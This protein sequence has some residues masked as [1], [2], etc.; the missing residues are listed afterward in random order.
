MKL[1]VS[2]GFLAALNILL[3]F[4]NQWYVLATVGPGKETDAL[5]AGMAFPQVV[6]AVLSG[7][8]AQVLVPLLAGDIDE[9]IRTEGWFCFHVSAVVFGA[10][11]VVSILFAGLWVPLLFPGFSSD[12]LSLTIELTRIQL[13]G[14]VFSGLSAVLWSVGQAR[15][16]FLW[17]AMTPPIG[18]IL[19]F[20]VLA[21]TVPWYGIRAAAWTSVMRVTLQTGVLLPLLGHYTS[22]AFSKKRLEQIMERL[23]PLVL[24][25]LYSKTG[26]L[27]DRFLSSMAPAGGL[28]LLYLAQQIYA[29]IA[30]VIHKSFT[31]S[32]IP[33]LT[34]HARNSN[35]AGFQFVYLKRFWWI[36]GLTLSGYVILA[37]FGRKTLHF[38]IGFGGVT[39]ENVQLLWWLLVVLGGVLVAGGMG[40]ISAA[41]FYAEGDTRIPAR[42]GIIGFTLG[43]LVKVFAFFHIGL[44]GIALGASVHQIFNTSVLHWLYKRRLQRVSNLAPSG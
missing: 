10:M 29:S 11:T 6:L 25:S 15:Q 24:V 9:S 20:F 27:L 42:V 8:L 35:W 30:D 14:M 28:S 38:L 36:A 43:S 37:T 5:F 4:I 21:S 2:L 18:A 34:A 19:A 13:L 17:V 32:M 23:R 33:A 12:S 22:P 26:P 44:L 1:L 7:S 41:A 3:S 16:R 40:Q 31:T 39:N